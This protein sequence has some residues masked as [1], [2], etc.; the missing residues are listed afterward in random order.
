VLLTTQDLDEADQLADRIAVL[1]H[2]RVVAEGTPDELKRRVPGSYVSVYFADS[3]TLDRAAAVL[4]EAVRDADT[5]TFRVPTDG[6]PDS[7]VALLAGLN[8]HAASSERVTV[9]TS[10][11]DEVFLALTGNPKQ[12]RL[13]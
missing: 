5:L 10:D 8:R 1:D 6:A 4:G 13:T 7:L 3:A 9:H 12:E 11:L 2:G